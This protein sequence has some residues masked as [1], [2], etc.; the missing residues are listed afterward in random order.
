MPTS[1][2][3]NWPRR[4]PKIP[5]SRCCCCTWKAFPIPSNWRRPRAL[6][7]G[8]ICRSS[9]SSRAGRR[10]DSAPP[11]H[12]PGRGLFAIRNGGGEG[13]LT[14]DAASM[15]GMPL[16]TLS[17]E[18]RKDLG[19][20]LPSFA[21]TAN[22]VDITAAL[23]TNS[24]LFSE[25]LP[26]IARDPAADAFLIAVPVAGKGYDVDAFARDAAAFARETGKP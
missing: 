10:Q 17:E 20:I 9:R 22:P 1:P 18:T 16:A 19:Q 4:W 2:P 8:A 11:V 24:G 7:P 23:L 13:V 6:Q 3:S 15:A 5:T 26:V 25:I 12:I 14:A 21:T